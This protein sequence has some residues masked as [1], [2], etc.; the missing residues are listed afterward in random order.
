MGTKGS[1]VFRYRGIYYIFYNSHDSY[2][3]YLGN[4]VVTEIKEIIVADNLQYLKDLILKIPLT[5]KPTE[6]ESI[7]HSIIENI[8]YYECFCYRTSNVEQQC[9]LFEEYVYTVDLDKNVFIV[10]SHT[11]PT[12]FKLDVNIP[13]DLGTYDVN[14]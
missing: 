3:S 12:V 9:G 7:F 6:T 4:K 10:N 1:V 5:E 13:D 11:G 14:D 8:T 2:F